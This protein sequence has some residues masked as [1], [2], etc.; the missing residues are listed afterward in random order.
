M[1]W[2]WSKVELRGKYKT[3]VGRSAGG[4]DEFVIVYSKGSKVVKARGDSGDK[5]PLPIK[6][7]QWRMS[8]TATDN[9]VYLL[10]LTCGLATKPGGTVP[11][12]REGAKGGPLALTQHGEQQCTGYKPQCSIGVE[13]GARGCFWNLGRSHN[14]TRPHCE[15]TRHQ[16]CQKDSRYQQ[17]TAG[18]Q[19]R[20]ERNTCNWIRQTQGERLII[21]I[22]IIIIIIDLYS[23]RTIQKN[24]AIQRAWLWITR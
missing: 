1:I 3:P 4:R 7:S 24:R 15:S 13:R 23:A 20:F 21:I 8:Q 6:C 12:T 14:Y 19:C 17:W 11:L 16:R 22:I 18:G 2:N 9:Q 5:L 10:A